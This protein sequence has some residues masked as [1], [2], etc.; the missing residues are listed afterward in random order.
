MCELFGRSAFAGGGA[1]SA[2]PVA[3]VFGRCP[4]THSLQ[5]PM[6]VAVGHGH[7][8]QCVSLRGCEPG[9]QIVHLPAV[10]TW[11][12]GQRTHLL[13]SGDGSSPTLH[14]VHA[15]VVRFTL[16]LLQSVPHCFPVNFTRHLQLE[17]VYPV[18]SS[19]GTHVALL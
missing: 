8:A 6:E 1:T 17:P 5:T 3:F 16:P 12:A 13:W 11:P 4:S 9:G 14:G 7:R 10:P 18:L 2:Q 15:S 19:V